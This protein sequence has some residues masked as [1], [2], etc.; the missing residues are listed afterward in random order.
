EPTHFDGPAM[1]SGK[2]STK[3]HDLE[4]TMAFQPP[5]SDEKKSGEDELVTAEDL[6]G[7]SEASA[8][9]LGDVSSKKGSSSVTGIDRLAEA[10]ESGVDLGATAP[11]EPSVEFDE[12]LEDLPESG[13][14]IDVGSI[15]GPIVSK[16]TP[17]K[18][19]KKDKK[20]KAAAK[21]TGDD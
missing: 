12:I 16:K 4:Q 5:S 10:L 14:D 6:E 7:S 9:D 11:P 15:E 8:V 19:G 3:S 17:D 2:D 21:A 20:D 13:D 18:K 1:G